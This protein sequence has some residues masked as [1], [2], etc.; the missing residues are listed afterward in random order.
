MYSRRIYDRACA[1][2]LPPRRGFRHFHHRLQRFYDGCARFRVASV[3]GHALD[4][5]RFEDIR[6]V[7]FIRDPRDLL[8]SG[9]Y[10]HIKG[11]ESWSTQPDPE[12]GD[13]EEVVGVIPSGL[14]PGESMQSYL[15]KVPLELGMEAELEF[16]TNHFRSMREWP[17]DDP[18]VR[19]FRYEDILGNEVA[20]FEEVFDFFGLPGLARASGIRYARRHAA[21]QKSAD[22][23]H[24]RNARAGQWRDVLP[25]SVVA[26]VDAQ[27]GD[28]LDRYGYPR[29]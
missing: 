8:V 23:I 21:S 3:S 15:K 28:V 27:Y 22:R 14:P 7:R 6:V 11:V 2:V 18:R 1:W 4:L 29:D 20:V 9:Y 24:I 12:P 13:W 5:E 10:Y 17:E 19:V 25:D 16:R 26:K